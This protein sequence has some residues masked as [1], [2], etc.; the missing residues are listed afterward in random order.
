MPYVS[1]GD[2]KYSNNH[3]S[4]NAA[5]NQSNMLRKLHKEILKIGGKLL[6]KR[7]AFIMQSTFGQMRPT[8]SVCGF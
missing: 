6:L 4:G 2:S 1:F 3:F 5:R 8:S 7:I